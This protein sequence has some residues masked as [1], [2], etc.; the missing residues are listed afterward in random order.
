MIRDILN[1]IP[2][3][4]IYQVIAFLIFFPMFIGI[5]IWIFRM[6][7]AYILKMEELP[8]EDNTSVES[9]LGD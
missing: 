3:G 6:S 5:L 9:K 8:L 4:G 7:K 1:S 2:G